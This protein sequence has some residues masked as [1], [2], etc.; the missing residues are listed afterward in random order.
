VNAGGK[1]VSASLAEKL[2]SH[3]GAF[4]KP[5]HENLSNREFQILC[6]I[7][8]GK[9]LKSIADELCVGE[10]TVSTYRSRIMEKMKMSTNSDLTRYALE[11]HLDGNRS[12]SE[13]D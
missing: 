2:V 3:L 9:S 7:A 8:R 13:F 12:D 6:M 10:K 11:N 1:Y 5:L 4:D